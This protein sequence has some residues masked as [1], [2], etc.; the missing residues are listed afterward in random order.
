M[1]MVDS[2]GRINNRHLE[3]AYQCL[4]SLQLCI[5]HKVPYRQRK[6]QRE[7]P[8]SGY[9]DCRF[10]QPKLQV[11]SAQIIKKKVEKGQW[12]PTFRILKRFAMHDLSFWAVQCGAVLRIR[13]DLIGSRIP[14][15]IL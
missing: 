12:L 1:S 8:K 7:S 2:V 14:H 15:I 11:F 9:K 3:P 6:T 13:F 10:Y 4:F 5:K